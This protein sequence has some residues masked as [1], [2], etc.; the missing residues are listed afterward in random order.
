VTKLPHAIKA[1]PVST[2]DKGTYLLWTPGLSGKKPRSFDGWRL[3]LKEPQLR[4]YAPTS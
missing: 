1:P 3:V 2:G 4:L